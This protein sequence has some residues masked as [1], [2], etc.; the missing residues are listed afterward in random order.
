M[1]SL[2]RLVRIE[3]VELVNDSDF[4]GEVSLQTKVVIYYRPK[5]QRG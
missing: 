3:H 2:D 4:T 1:Q 5:S